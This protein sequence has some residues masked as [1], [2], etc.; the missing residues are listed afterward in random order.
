MNDFNFK[1]RVPFA[2]YTHTTKIS[3]FSMPHVIRLGYPWRLSSFSDKRLEFSRNFN[4]PTGLESDQEGW[5]VVQCANEVKLLEWTLNGQTSSVLQNPSS[6]LK[7]A[8]RP[9]LAANNRLTLGFSRDES[10]DSVDGGSLNLVPS[11]FAATVRS[12]EVGR[13]D[14]MELS[15][16][17]KVTLEIDSAVQTRDEFPS[18]PNGIS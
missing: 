1:V 14:R 3:N 6:L 2:R 9:W 15:P 4:L 10:P 11:H 8:I 12:D 7:L 13:P 5:L 16:W 17:A 18:K